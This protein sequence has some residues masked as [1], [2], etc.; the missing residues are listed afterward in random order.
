MTP[1]LKMYSKFILPNWTLFGHILTWE[2]PSS[3]TI[4]KC[5]IDECYFMCR[6]EATVV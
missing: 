5:S 2:S 6:D 1:L 3:D 4:T